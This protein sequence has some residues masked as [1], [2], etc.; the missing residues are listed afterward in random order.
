MKSRGIALIVIVV[1][2]TAALLYA[3]LTASPVGA[4]PSKQRTCGVSGCHSGTPS[5]SVTAK[6]SKTGLAKHGTYTVTITIKLGSTGKTGYWIAR[7]NASGVTGK[8]TGVFGGPGSKTIW[9]VTM[10]A[11]GKKGTYYY[12]VFGVKGPP[13]SGETSTAKYHIKVT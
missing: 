12:K 4:N 10:N 7:S 11:P 13:P 6:P 5:G 1:L 3:T 2:A 9:K 8:S